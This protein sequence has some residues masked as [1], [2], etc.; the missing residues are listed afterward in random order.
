MTS[1]NENY[2]ELAADQA[3]GLVDVWVTKYAL[4]SG[5]DK[6][7]AK[8]CYAVSVNMISYQSKFGYSCHAHGSDWHRTRTEAVADVAK[9]KAAKIASLRKQ[10]A[11]LEAIDPEKVVPV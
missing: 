5:V 6:L 7:F 9:R 2:T 3:D 10:I 11:K 8:V 1:N 4:T